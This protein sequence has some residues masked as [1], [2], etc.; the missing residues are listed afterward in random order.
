LAR[1]LDDF[2]EHDLGEVISRYIRGVEALLVD[3][4]DG[5]GPDLAEKARSVKGAFPGNYLSSFWRSALTRERGADSLSVEE[6][7]AACDR[8]VVHL[9]TE[10][11]DSQP[12]TADGWLTHHQWIVRHPAL[13]GLVRKNRKYD[14]GLRHGAVMDLDGHLIELRTAKI[15]HMEP[16]DRV[17]LLRRGKHEATDCYN[18]TRKIGFEPPPEKDFYK[19][20]AVG[21]AVC[22]LGIA[23]ILVTILLAIR[24]IHGVGDS[25]SILKFLVVG[26]PSVA[27]AGIGF[28]ILILGIASFG[29]N[30][31]FRRTIA[32]E[33]ELLKTYD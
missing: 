29:M 25:P 12:R 6:V 3:E 21:A 30:F 18:V 24:N 20:V 2:Q 27:A 7:S 13:G 32:K 1:R 5:R 19:F 23:G 17:A 15:I 10:A 16:G 22:V 31:E 9:I 11:V 14:D 26:V 4:F 8:A 28:A 33:T